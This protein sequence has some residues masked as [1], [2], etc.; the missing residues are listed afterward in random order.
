VLVLVTELRTVVREVVAV[1]GAVVGAGVAAMTAAGWS[2]AFDAC[3]FSLAKIVMPPKLLKVIA[4]ASTR[5][6]MVEAMSGLRRAR[7]V[8]RIG[9][10]PRA[11]GT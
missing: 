6:A 4:A 2:G 1:V 8:M 5:S 9:E 11:G 3:R 10:H 7:T